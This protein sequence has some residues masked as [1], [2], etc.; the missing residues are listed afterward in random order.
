MKAKE[1]MLAPY[2]NNMIPHLRS[3]IVDKVEA[4]SR[5]AVL[6]QIYTI[7]CSSEYQYSDKY[8]QAKESTE[9]YCVTELAKELES[10]GYMIGKPY[11]CEDGSQLDLDQLIEDDA[12]DVDA[13]QE[14][15]EKMFPELYA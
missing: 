1:P 14:W 9:K 4:E 5:L 11:P 8:N 6:E 3:Y 12:K 15:V 2:G 13:P 10:E 7:I